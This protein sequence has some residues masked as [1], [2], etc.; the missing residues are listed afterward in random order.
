RIARTLEISE[1]TVKNHLSGIYAKIHV[2]DR[3]QATLYAL[4]TGV[5]DPRS[6]PGTPLQADRG[7]AAACPTP[8]TPR[9]KGVLALLSRG[10]SNRRIARTLEISEKTVKNHLSGIYAKIH[11][12][13]RTQA[14]LYARRT[15][16]S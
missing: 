10:L 12:T 15:G 8:L 3:T 11:V 1:K 5:A 14:L 2:T 13:D 6:V 9:E 7:D 16:L 4:R